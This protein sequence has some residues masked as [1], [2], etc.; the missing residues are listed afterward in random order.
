MVAYLDALSVAE[1]ERKIPLLT[2]AVEDLGRDKSIVDYVQ[3]SSEIHKHRKAARRQVGTLNDW[4]SV[5]VL[6]RSLHMA[7]VPLA[8]NSK[9]DGAFEIAAA[10]CNVSVGYVQR[11][12]YWAE[13]RNR[14]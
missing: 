5:G 4:Y 10:E 8:S 3:R 6:V 7:G 2:R 13:N 9:S 11:A 14:S 12:Y 1:R